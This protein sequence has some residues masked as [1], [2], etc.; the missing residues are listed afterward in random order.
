MSGKIATFYSWKGGVGRTMAVANVGLQLARSGIKVLL[1]DWDL[2]APGLHLYFH[3]Q[4]ETVASKLIVKKQPSDSTGLLGLLSDVVAKKQLAP[5]PRAWTRRCTRFEV[6]KT[7][8]FQ[9]GTF[10]L[11]HSGFGSSN[12]IE[13]LER[14]SWNEFYADYNGGQWLEEL[15]EQ[16]LANYDLI[17][18]DS[19]TGLT[20]SGGVCTV[21]IPDMIV[22]VF[23]PNLQSLQDGLSFLRGVQRARSTFPYVRRPMSVVPLLA[24]WEGHRE[25][26]LSAKWLDEISRDV[27]P[28]VETWLPSDLPVRRM[29]ERLR[30]PHVA[31]FSFG[32]PLPVLS[33][34]LTDPE[35]PGLSFD[36]LARLLAGGLSGAGRI[37]EPEYQ[38]TG[39]YA[40]ATITGGKLTIEKLIDSLE[41]N[42]EAETKGLLD[43]D[44]AEVSSDQSAKRS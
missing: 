31:R 23:T 28:L 39:L 41:A 22:Y 16:W 3:A 10:D 26:D 34:S 44:E 25:V 29:L 40:H 20:D 17:L 1:V 32:E 5:P 4:E 37:I 2:E 11:L 13:N 19:R 43:V 7:P 38:P 24:R 42:L 15:R 6:A 21:Q 18:I 9:K 12:Y 35:L 14:F 8:G 36:L 30:V 27:A 33:H